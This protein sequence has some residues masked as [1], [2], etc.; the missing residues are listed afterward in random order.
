MA[1]LYFLSASL[2]HSLSAASKT[3]KEKKTKKKEKAEHTKKDT[4]R[5]Q[6]V[7]ELSSL[8]F[9]IF[10]A[11]LVLDSLLLSEPTLCSS[12]ILA[13]TWF[14]FCS[15]D[16]T[17]AHTVGGGWWIEGGMR[18]KFEEGFALP[19]DI[20]RGEDRKNNL[21]CSFSYFKIQN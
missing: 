16:R 9:C 20:L 17:I 8:S 18:W 13:F 21:F 5:R 10:L 12:L 4:T 3:E 15:G 1:T 14:N 11:V 2:C 19:Q 6:A 7:E